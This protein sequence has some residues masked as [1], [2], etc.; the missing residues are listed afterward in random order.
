MFSFQFPFLGLLLLPVAVL[1][2]PAGDPCSALT[3]L[4]IENT[5]ITNA[6]YQVAGTNFSM[7]DTSYSGCGSYFNVAHANVCRVQ[8]FVNTSSTSSVAFEVW[9]PDVWYGRFMGLGNGGLAGCICP[10]FYIMLLL[11]LRL[12]TL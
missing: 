11:T 2:G 10:N 1:S 12:I 4:H 8:G 7:P 9:L 3:S 5:T 6:F